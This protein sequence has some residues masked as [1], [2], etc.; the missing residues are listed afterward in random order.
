MRGMKFYSKQSN[1]KKSR[2]GAHKNTTYRG[3]C[4]TCRLSI[5]SPEETEPYFSGTP[6]Y[7]S[8][9]LHTLVQDRLEKLMQEM[10]AKEEEKKK[11]RRKKDDQKEDM[12]SLVVGTDDYKVKRVAFAVEK[13]SFEPRE[14]LK[15]SMVDMIKANGMVEPHELRRLLQCY[16]AMNSEG[17]AALILEVFHEVCSLIFMDSLGPQV[18]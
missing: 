10:K 4:C 16:L 6:E 3:F 14:D 7:I 17:C 15:W 13:E 5:S 8:A 1:H 18:M 11:K 12:S 9:T 2:R